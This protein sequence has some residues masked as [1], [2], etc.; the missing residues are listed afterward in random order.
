M[1]KII[2]LLLTLNCSLQIC[3]A[4]G[5]A[6]QKAAKSV[7]TLTTYKADGSILTTTH[8]AYYGN[9]GEGIASFSPFVGAASAIIIDATGKRANVEAI[10]GANEIYDICRFKLSNDAGVPLPTSSAKVSSSAWIVGYS[11][12]K[13][14]ISK[15]TVKNAENFLDKYTYY[16]FTEEITEDTEGCPIIND[17]GQIVGLAQRSKTTYDINSTD[18]GYYLT[19]ESN[20]L[21]MQ[22]AAIRK[23]KIRPALPAV[24]EQARIMLLMLTADNDSLDVVNTTKEYIA[25]YPTDIDG[26]AAMARYEIA[27]N[28]LNKASKSMED[29]IK[30]V[31]KEEA[32]YE[33][34]K[35]IYST[36][37]Y[38]PDSVQTLWNLGMAEDNINK[39][40][41]LNSLPMYRHLLARI[42]YLQHDFHSALNIY[43]ELNNTSFA[44]SD[45]Y[46][47]AAQSKANLGATPQEI[48]PYMDKAIEACPKPLTRISAPHFLNRGLMLASMGEDKKALLDLN[49][50][51]TLMAFRASDDFYYTRYN[52][53]VKLRQYQQAINDIA[54][55]AV[56]NPEEPTY[57]AELASLQLRVGQYENAV[58]TCDLGITLTTEYSDIYIVKGVALYQLQRKAE[59]KEAL[60]KAKEL[61]DERADQY[62]EKYK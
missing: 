62:L 60:L 31:N 29:A 37:A 1:K 48:L 26:Y 2:I 25:Q 59:A 19:L 8:G 61:G 30:H 49:V 32:Y 47:E 55:A 7:F 45:T 11:T 28:N 35:L 44:S 10:I 46:Y 58:K 56:I 54:H 4:Q 38:Q 18:A 20:G 50:Y 13:P 17:A 22:D 23:T 33:Y 52:I 42:K 9:K 36:L 57:L 12:K 39:A 34:A 24:Q 51:D 27:H 15:V 43:E 21:S 41:A 3:L 40:I 14:S 5:S 53:E 16:T 6:V